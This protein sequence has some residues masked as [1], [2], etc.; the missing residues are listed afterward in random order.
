MIGAQP[1]QTR[2]IA[3]FFSPTRIGRVMQAA[4]LL[5]AVPCAYAQAP[6][7]PALVIAATDAGIKW[8][9]CPAFLPRG[10]TLGVLH[11]DPARPNADVMLRVPGRS[12]IPMHTHTSAERMVL[13]S[14]ELSVGYEGQKP[15][16]LKPGS[17]AF[18]PAKVPHGATCM[19]TVPC[20]LFI[21]FEGPVDAIPVAPVK[22]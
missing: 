13:I 2:R 22:K 10:C 17:Y 12:S 1:V 21:A 3:M 4:L 16:T 5:A 6:D 11:G 19:S 15:A 7:N 14:G 9:A 8:G 18:G 20:V